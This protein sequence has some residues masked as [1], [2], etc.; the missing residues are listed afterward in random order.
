MASLS[1]LSQW[2][3]WRYTARYSKLH[4]PVHI[5]KLHICS[6]GIHLVLHMYLDTRDIVS[7][8]RLVGVIGGLLTR[9]W[10][11]NIIGIRD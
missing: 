8:G 1:Q 5:A 10:L 11:Y 3:V 7:Y 4:H 6:L 9:F 2:S